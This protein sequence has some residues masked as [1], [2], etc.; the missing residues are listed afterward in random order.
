MYHFQRRLALAFYS[1]EFLISFRY[2]SNVSELWYRPISFSPELDILV[3]ER[4]IVTGT[5]FDSVN[6][7][8]NL[9]IPGLWRE[10]VPVCQIRH[11]NSYH[12]L[13]THVLCLLSFQRW[14]YKKELKFKTWSLLSVTNV[15][16]QASDVLLKKSNCNKIRTS[17]ICLFSWRYNPLGSYFHS[18][19][20]GF[21]LLLFE[22]SWSHTTTRHSR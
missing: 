8:K 16:A 2:F 18:P 5:Y 6:P 3:L 17:R 4:A 7:R 14:L 11:S 12:S 9:R 15:V 1:Y 22:V 13:S 21:S 19:V 10:I 20:E